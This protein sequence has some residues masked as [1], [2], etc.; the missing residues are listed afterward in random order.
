ML[1]HLQTS[2]EKRNLITPTL[3]DARVQSLDVLYKLWETPR[4]DV[5]TRKDGHECGKTD[6]NPSI[7]LKLRIRVSPK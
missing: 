3:W 7:H 6:I 4:H 2:V 5:L 1:L